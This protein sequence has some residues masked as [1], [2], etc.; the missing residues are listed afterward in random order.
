MN[1]GA[2]SE[3]EEMKIDV[4]ESYDWREAYPQCV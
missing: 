1:M 2:E 3:Q 4:P